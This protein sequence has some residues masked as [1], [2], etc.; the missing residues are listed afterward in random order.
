[1]TH[2]LVGE[3]GI[4]SYVC[5]SAVYLVGGMEKVIPGLNNSQVFP[6]VLWWE[7]SIL[8]N[9]TGI[10]QPCLPLPW[11]A[12]AIRPRPPEPSPARLSAPSAHQANYAS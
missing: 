11:S 7:P 4:Q 12:M 8:S 6:I 5:W 1:M 2:E 10:I 9:S 3:L